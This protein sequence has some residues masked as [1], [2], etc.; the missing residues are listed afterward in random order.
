MKD[1]RDEI[2]ASVPNA[3]FNYEASR[4][5]RIAEKS[6]LTTISNGIEREF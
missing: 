3:S 2:D 5:D 6:M 1:Y 4:F